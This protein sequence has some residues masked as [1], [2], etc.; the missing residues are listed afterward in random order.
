MCLGHVDLILCEPGLSCDELL[1]VVCEALQLIRSNRNH[2]RKN[3]ASSAIAKERCDLF[4]KPDCLDLR[5]YTS[6]LSLADAQD[7]VRIVRL[8]TAVHDVCPAFGKVLPLLNLKSHP[9]L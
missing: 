5:A 6:G 3:D 2:I 9:C 1:Q 7:E 4:Y 8:R